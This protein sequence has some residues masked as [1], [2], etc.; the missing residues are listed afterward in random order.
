[1]FVVGYV[2]VRLSGEFCQALCLLLIFSSCVTPNTV[3]VGKKVSA[4]L[5]GCLVLPSHRQRQKGKLTS[6]RWP[7]L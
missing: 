4:L 1:M 3:V 7:S 6:K 5:Q 2:R